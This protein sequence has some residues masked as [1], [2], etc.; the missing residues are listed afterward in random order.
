[1]TAVSDA[2]ADKAPLE[3]LMVAMD[4]VDTVRH[5]DLIIGR[6]LDSEGRRQRLL[7]RLR[8][9]YEAQGIEVSDAALAAGVDALEE[10][11]FSYVPT[12]D[13]FSTTL[14]RLYVRRSRWLKPV[15]G[16]LTFGL[17]I[18]LAWYATVGLP[19]SRLLAAL[20]VNIEAT[21]AR[22]TAISGNDEATRLAPR[23]RNELRGSNRVSTQ[24]DL[25]RL[26]CA[27]HQS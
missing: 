11:R 23:S 24:R 1:M 22:I 10:D 21:H 20:P 3:D 6:E 14:A 7:G 19:E 5:R 12:A 8:Q 9:I 17:V 4:V 2:G 15:V 18:W 13:S 26:A 16:I 25:G 27:G